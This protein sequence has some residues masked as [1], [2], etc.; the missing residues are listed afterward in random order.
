LEIQ[1]KIR[2]IKNLVNSSFLKGNLLFQVTA[3][4]GV[5]SLLNGL[6]M[7]STVTVED[8]GKVALIFQVSYL[9]SPILNL[10]IGTQFLRGSLNTATRK[11]ASFVVIGFSIVLS[12]ISF[13]ICRALSIS[14]NTTLELILAIVFATVAVLQFIVRAN[15]VAAN[16][17][18]N[19]LKLVLFVNGTLGLL[20]VFLWISHQ[21]EVWKWLLALAMQVPFW[22]YFAIRGNS[23]QRVS[24]RKLLAYFPFTFTELSNMIT[25]RLDRVLLAV[26]CGNKILAIYVVTATVTEIITWVAVGESDSSIKGFVGS[27]P[28]GKNLKTYV[29][30]R[31]VLLF[32]GGIFLSL[33]NYFLVLP[34][35]GGSYMNGQELILPLSIGALIYS[36]NVYLQARIMASDQPMVLTRVSLLSALTAILIYPLAIYRFEIMGAAWGSLVVYTISL[37]ITIKFLLKIYELDQGK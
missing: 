30:S 8:R 34:L 12:V 37:L 33:L 3:V 10:G 31:I 32:I 6:L 1:K 25:Q 26:F 5:I 11:F 17:T 24:F 18:K 7:A 20:S 9:L 35:L 29:I 4:S 14:Q 2:S 13:L 15:Y 27:R 23:M 28:S 36:L 21:I 19:Y 16:K 22:T